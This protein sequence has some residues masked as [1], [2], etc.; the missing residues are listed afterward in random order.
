MAKKR[1]RT[2]IPSDVKAVLKRIEAWRETREKLG[3]MP[4][5]LWQAATAVARLHGTGRVARDLR[6]HFQALKKRVVQQ[7]PET[8]PVTASDPTFVEVA[9]RP[10]EPSRECVVE[11]ER[12]G[13]GRMTIRRPDFRALMAL[14]ATF[15]GG[16]V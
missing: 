11:M 7:Y 13:G 16:R 12:V 8:L 6:V 1:K 3:P 5:E 14:S 15:W 4:E 2:T 10:P 9:L